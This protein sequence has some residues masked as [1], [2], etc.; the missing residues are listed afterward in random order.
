[1]AELVGGV[2][3]P[4]TPM[5]G[6]EPTGWRDHGDLEQAQ[7]AKKDLVPTSRSSADLFEELDLERMRG[8]YE[9]MQVAIGKIAAGLA[10]MA[11][12]VLVIVGDDQQ[13]LFLDDGMPALS[14]FWGSN[15][16]DRPPGPD[17]YP[18]TMASAYKWYH[19]DAEEAYETCS[20]LGLHLVEQLMAGNFDVAQFSMQSSSRSLGHAFTWVYRRL[21]LGD[22]RIPF[23]PVILNTYYPPNQPT[24]ARCVALGRA[25]AAAI[26]TW[27][28]ESRV[29]LVASGGLSHPIID[30]ALDQQVLSALCDHNSDALQ[31][32]PLEL[33]REGSSEIRNWITVGSALADSDVEVVDYVPA[34]RSLLGSGCGTAFA[35]WHMR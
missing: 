12:D 16:W 23:T 21:L 31:A 6:I 27:P 24:P 14:V 20:L 25:L 3:T 13:E 35:L 8:R 15:M 26:R 4:H 28:S 30:E 1:M 18:P 9:R 34:Y 5:L 19:A 7:L 17:A 33:L 29:A 10:E 11:P 2:G 32:L 22:R